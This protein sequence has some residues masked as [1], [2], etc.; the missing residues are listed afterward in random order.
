MHARDI[1]ERSHRQE[2]M[3]LNPGA[4]AW[5]QLAEQK[6][7]SNVDAVLG[8]NHWLLSALERHGRMA[9]DMVDGFRAETAKAHARKQLTETPRRC[10]SRTRW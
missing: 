9:E 7:T 8:T 5:F 10:N 3:N 4:E 2:P 1:G 6:R